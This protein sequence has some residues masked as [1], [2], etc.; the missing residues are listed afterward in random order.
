MASVEPAP[1]APVALPVP[2][3]ASRFIVEP[4]VVPGGVPGVDVPVRS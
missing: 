2:V 4:S 1:L 3:A